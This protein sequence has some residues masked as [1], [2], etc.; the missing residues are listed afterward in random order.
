M[1]EL[2]NEQLSEERYREMFV[3]AF[4]KYD[5]GHIPS[6]V[7]T[8]YDGDNPVGFCTCEAHGRG[9]LHLQYAGFLKSVSG[10]NKYR[11][12]IEVLRTL[13]GMGYP[14]ITGIINSLNN[15]ALMWALRS[16]FRIVGVR[17]VFNGNL[18]V[19]IVHTQE[20]TDG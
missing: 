2:R 13:H 14:I 5:E 8:V 20:N 1:I 7:F 6:N 15:R 17:Q 12:Y 9:L 3:E 10:I 4:G 19:E 18:L 16:G 11:Y